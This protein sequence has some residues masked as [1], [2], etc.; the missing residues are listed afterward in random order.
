MATSSRLQDFWKGG[1]LV[2]LVFAVF[3][4]ALGCGYVWDDNAYVTRNPVLSSPHGLWHIWFST[5]QSSQYFPLV[6]TVLRAE[7]KLWGLNPLG[8]HFI[9]LL[10]HAANVLLA[11]RI[12]KRLKIP[13][14][15]F[16]AALFAIHPVQVE[17][18]VWITEIKNLLS[19][20]FYLLAIR[21]WLILTH[22]ESN[23]FIRH[24]TLLLFY[25]LL[26]L[27]AKT[28]AC[29]L[30]V[31]LLLLLWFRRQPI[32]SQRILQTIPL[33]LFG[34][35]MGLVSIWI[36][37][38]HMG[39]R[40]PEFEFSIANRII[41]VGQA[42]W[43][44]LGKLIWPSPII[45]IY[46]RWN[47]HP[48]LW[49]SYSWTLG[50]ILMFIL[51][52]LGQRYWGRGPLT[53][54]F[55]YSALLAPML[56]FITLYTFRYTFVSDHYQYLACL[57]PFALFSA[58]LT[59]FTVQS[60]LTKPLI[61]SIIFCLGALTRQQSY[62]YENG[63]TL[64]KDTLAKNPSS[65]IARNNLGILLMERGEVL[66][67]EAHYRAALRL[68]PD[69]AE[70][71]N[72]LGKLLEAGARNEEALLHYRVAHS[73][74]PDSYIILHNLGALLLWTGKTN[75]G[76]SKL[77]QSLQKWPTSAAECARL[78]AALSDQGRLR[79]AFDLQ[80]RIIQWRPSAEAYNNM[81]ILQIIQN[82]PRDAIQCFEK[83]LKI[84][85]N[86]QEALSNLQK[87]RASVH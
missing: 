37:Y 60:R 86:M 76:L 15:W 31:A 48:E 8:Y 55:F 19:T 58:G 2:L 14:A 9:N 57:G 73:T 44:Y 41:R 84:R 65:W 18:V 45:F 33:F 16:A 75:E 64:W 21:E 22:L 53:A 36:E 82:R 87:A 43:F 34:L 79:E 68:K 12:L 4:P 3:W 78:V 80:S 11:W 27:F 81:G 67:A 70:A 1:M 6:Y 83:A 52:I 39:T 17:S 23:Y 29:T 24:Y 69:Y 50:A 74:N 42:L 28:T 46:P 5:K 35:V 72:N 32:T 62:A 7:Y 61:L 51:L 13:G 66:Q 49:T 40:G 26:A 38:H 59:R 25:S 47:V 30:P 71:H 63:E 20:L 54:M 85:P 10:F 77:D 56:G